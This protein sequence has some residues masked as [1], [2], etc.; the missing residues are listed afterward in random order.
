VSVRSVIERSERD[1]GFTL[2]ELMIVVM[3]LGVLMAI[4]LPAF[5]G[6]RSRAQD[7]AARQGAALTLEAAKIV[8]TAHSDFTEATTAELEA[9]EPSLTYVDAGVSSTNASTASRDAPDADTFIAAVWSASGTCFFIRDQVGTGID[10]GTIRG[11]TTADCTAGNSGA[12][13]FGSW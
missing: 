12:A 7:S 4:G 8:Y 10:V 1:D 11:G 13:T 5:L 9:S 3:I 2:V 6:A